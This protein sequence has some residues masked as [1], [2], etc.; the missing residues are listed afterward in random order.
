MGLLLCR[1][2]LL[3][4]AKKDDVAE[5]CMHIALERKSWIET[6]F[7]LKLSDGDSDAFPFP[8]PAPDR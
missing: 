4:S 5:T 3:L 8:I 1:R 7:D 6:N 2:M